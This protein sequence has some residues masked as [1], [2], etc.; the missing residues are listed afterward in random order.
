MVAPH[1]V[2]V[3][4]ILV[5]AK[6]TVGSAVVENSISPTCDSVVVVRVVVC[7]KLIGGREVD[8]L[9]AEELAKEL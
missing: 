6:L 2:H 9:L 8:V 4:I 3:R 1:H 5:L 7:T